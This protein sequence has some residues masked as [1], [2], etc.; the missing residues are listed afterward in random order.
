MFD[1]NIA[2]DMKIVMADPAELDGLPQDYIDRH[3]PGPDRKI[4]LT[5]DYPDSIPVL[6]F[7]KSDALRHR[8]AIAFNPRAYPKNAD[9]LMS[10]M[11]TRYEIATL[12]GYSS[13]ADYNDADKM[14]EN[15]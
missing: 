4:Q 10:L 5:T 7:A 9:V 6:T 15:G 8:M 11:K 2:D 1:R 14:I 3:K 12:L 13:W